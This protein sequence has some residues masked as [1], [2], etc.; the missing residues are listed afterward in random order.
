MQGQVAVTGC[1]WCHFVIWAEGHGS[2][3]IETI[4]F[5]EKF[6]HEDVLSGL[7]YYAE[8]ALF[9]ELLTCR[10]KRLGNLTSRYVSYKEWVA[11]YVLKDIG[12]LKKRFMVL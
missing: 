10:I 12:N 5:D 8:H 2:T 9:P 7:L 1:K 11:G 6:F 4:D 3:H